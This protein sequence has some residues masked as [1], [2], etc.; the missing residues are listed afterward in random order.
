[1]KIIDYQTIGGKN[2]I[3]SYI[4][5]LP[6]NEKVI[7]Y[8]IRESIFKYGLLAFEKLNTK[9]LVDKIYEIKF[10]NQRIAYILDGDKVYFLHMFQKQ[11]NKTEKKD[12]LIAIKRAKKEGI[13]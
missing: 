5:K 12:L 10:S 2:V 3:I 4:E 1:M 11:K 6:K 7:A 9:K 8:K 13:Y